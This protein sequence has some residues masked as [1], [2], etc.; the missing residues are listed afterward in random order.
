M[1]AAKDVFSLQPLT[2]RGPEIE[3]ICS[4]L[5]LAALLATPDLASVRISRGLITEDDWADARDRFERLFGCP[6]E[7]VVSAYPGWR[8]LPHLETPPG[9]QRFCLHDDYWVAAL[10]RKHAAQR[11]DGQL[12]SSLSAIPEAPSNRPKEAEPA[13][14]VAALIC[15]STV[16]G[17]H[18]PEVHSTKEKLPP[19]VVPSVK[20]L[21]RPQILPCRFAT[22]GRWRVF[23]ESLK[24]DDLQVRERVSF[25]S[26][27]LNK[28]AKMVHQAETDIVGLYRLLIKSSPEGVVPGECY[29][30][31]WAAIRGLTLCALI[32][33]DCDVQRA[34]ARVW[35]KKDC[36]YLFAA[37]KREY[38]SSVSTQLDDCQYE[39]G[40]KSLQERTKR[41]LPANQ[42][43][44]PHG[45]HERVKNALRSL[46]LAP[47]EGHTTSGG[48][49]E[50]P[51]RNN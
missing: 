37:I 39:P 29:H 28:I 40:F 51:R 4:R 45:I 6:I 10:K 32:Q 12:D 48:S 11:A 30:K 18:S 21:V 41:L 1:K 2:L 8:P 46:G 33:E 44:S 22:E 34:K 17:Q 47:Y 38:G 16:E 42:Q 5:T 7:S 35:M 20:S 26:Q 13:P 14:S 23:Y 9:E 15:V 24:N 36:S 25:P 31:T 50:S 19:R 27:P 43:F 3:Q 49:E